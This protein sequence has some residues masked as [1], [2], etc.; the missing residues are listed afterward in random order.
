M[1][2]IDAGSESNDQGARVQMTHDDANSPATRGELASLESRIRQDFTEFGSR[3]EKTLG[4]LSGLVEEQRRRREVQWPLV[5]SIIALVAALFG[6]GVKNLVDVA[7][8]KDAVVKHDSSLGDHGA[9]IGSLEAVV[10]QRASMIANV[11]G[12]TQRHELTL[13][14]MAARMG[15]VEAVQAQRATMLN[16][17]IEAVDDIRPRQ[18]T[19]ESSIQA[20]QIEEETQHR[21]IVDM[22]NMDVQSIE[23]MMQLKH[24]DIP[25]RDY[26][27]GQSVGRA[28][29]P[30]DEPK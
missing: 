12:A 20:L 14:Q 24:A 15:A 3:M 6:F 28:S 30:G 26:W 7:G 27:A 13:G 18:R 9:R 25:P 5:I 10:A 22:H 19:L 21:W 4:A 1:V 11:D 23:R 2:R 29:T 17:L 16:G 8:A